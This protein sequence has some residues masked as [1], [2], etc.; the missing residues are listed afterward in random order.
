MPLKK[1]LH[2]QDNP[3][4]LVDTNSKAKEAAKDIA[5]SSLIGIDT[6]YDS[7]R[8]FRER[9]CLI[10]IKAQGKTYLFDPF[11][12]LDFSFLG[13][14]FADTSLCKIMHAGDNDI[15][16]LKRDYDFVFNNVFD[17]HR[18]ASLLGCRRLSLANVVGEYLGIEFEKNKKMQRSKWDRRPLTE[19]Q[20]N[21]AVLDTA[22]LFDLYGRLEEGITRQ[23]LEEEAAK[24]FTDMTKNRWKKKALDN[25]GHKKIASYYTLTEKQKECLRRLFRW[26]F[27]KAKEI[28]RAIFMILSD[29][30]LVHLSSLEIG[31]INELMEDRLLPAEKVRLFGAELVELLNIGDENNNHPSPH[32][33][34]GGMGGFSGENTKC[35]Y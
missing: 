2:M 6:E 19:E 30:A 16:I 23:S 26:R 18:A 33:C 20:I 3:W 10:Q 27:E 14:Y 29:Q 24:I 5:G 17:T 13:E 32:P 12:E 4:L 22:Y 34:K 21:Y 8:Y 11:G 1:G 31:S 35:V 25:N 7:F 28:N 9:L 15:R